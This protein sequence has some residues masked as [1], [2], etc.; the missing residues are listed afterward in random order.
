MW[1]AQL[2][3]G[4]KYPIDV[5]LIET[6]IE[7][8]T[9]RYISLTHRWNDDIMFQTK[10]ASIAQMKRRFPAH[11]IS[12]TFLDA[13]TLAFKLGVEYIWI[14]SI[15]IIQDDAADWGAEALTMGKVYSNS[16]ITLS[17][18]TAKKGLHLPRNPFLIKPCV[19]SPKWKGIES[20]PLTVM[21]PQFWG[22]RIQRSP[23]GTRGW[24]IQ[25]RWLSARVLHFVFDQ[26]AW[27]CREE[28]MSEAYP[29]GLPKEIS[30]YGRRD[31]KHAKTTLAVGEGAINKES[32]LHR[33]WNSVLD[34]YG[35]AELTNEGDKLVAI[36]GVAE[37][38]SVK[39]D[40]EWVAGLWKKG[41]PGD[42]LWRVAKTRRSNKPQ[43]IDIVGGGPQQKVGQ[44]W[45]TRLKGYQAPS[46]SWASVNGDIISGAYIPLD[47]PESMISLV[48]ISITPLDPQRP[49][50]K[51]TSARLT[52]NGTL[53][54]LA[55]NPSDWQDQ[56]ETAIRNRQMAPIPPD[57]YIA[58][59]ARKKATP[60]NGREWET[61]SHVGLVL[62]DQLEEHEDIAV[63]CF[64]PVRMWVYDNAGHQFDG[65]HMITGLCLMPTW[66][67]RGEYKR[68]GQM[69][70]SKGDSKLFEDGEMFRRE[71]EKSGCEPHPTTLIPRLYEEGKFGVFSIV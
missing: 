31:F 16:L 50:G 69:S 35:R 60:S 38:F 59:L 68:L 1:L 4:A 18:T 52:L 53:Y 46:W 66:K 55:M 24:I 30:R 20:K 65:M 7:R 43:P 3:T 9:G 22:D 28:T 41:L 42:L 26:L 44:D 57:I 48:E 62:P 14:D 10:T 17:A 11:W 40:D 67:R 36:A 58:G 56:Y 45:S 15:C 12:A 63:S 2:A 5:K 54:P 64:L 6:A 33:D 49:L 32:L 29:F 27:E 39:M 13:I 37:K 71:G 25:E 8:P 70:F 23:C 21:D 51:I 34:T 19:I 61:P 47:S